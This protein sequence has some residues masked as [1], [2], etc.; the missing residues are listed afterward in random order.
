[1]RH[2]KRPPID[3][4]LILGL[5]MQVRLNREEFARRL[6]VRRETVWRW[7]KGHSNP[8]PVHI[9]QMRTLWGFSFGV[10]AREDR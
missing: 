8:N 1:V 3:P 4:K 6:M 10:K 7:E 9:R 2:A 5:R